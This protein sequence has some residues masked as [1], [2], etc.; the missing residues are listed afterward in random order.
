MGGDVRLEQ[1]ILKANMVRQTGSQW[2]KYMRRKLYGHSSLL[3]LAWDCGCTVGPGAVGCPAGGGGAED[4]LVV[5]F[6]SGVLEGYFL[7]AEEDVAD[8]AALDEEAP[9]VDVE[10]AVGG[11]T[12]AVILFGSSQDPRR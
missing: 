2:Q 9:I 1:G 10:C 8:R 11:K 6:D 7:R 12:N 3:P 5:G 4:V